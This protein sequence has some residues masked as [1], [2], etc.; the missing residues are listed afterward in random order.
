[1]TDLVHRVEDALIQ[2]AMRKAGGQQSKAGE[3]LGLAR[4]TFQSKMNRT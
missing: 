4:T 1:M 2:W 3:I